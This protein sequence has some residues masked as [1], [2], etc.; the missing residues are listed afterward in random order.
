MEA[1]QA[2]GGKCV[3]EKLPLEGTLGFNP[4]QTIYM[5][6]N[7]YNTL[8]ESKTPKSIIGH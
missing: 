4:F 3:G 7:L 2:G 6:K 5:H 1:F 8:E